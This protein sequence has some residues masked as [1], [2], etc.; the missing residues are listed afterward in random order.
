MF[1]PEGE[2]QRVEEER[3]DNDRD[4]VVVRDRVEKVQRVQDRDRQ[5]FR[6]PPQPPIVAEIDQ[7]D[8]LDRSPDLLRQRFT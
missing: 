2:K 5:R 8:D 4:A 7:I 6:H 3:K 1:P